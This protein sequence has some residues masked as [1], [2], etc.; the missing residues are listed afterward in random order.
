MNTD[1]KYVIIGQLIEQSV[2][3]QQQIEELKKQIE[4]KKE[5]K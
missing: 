5:D 1:I 2:L 4:E 3:L